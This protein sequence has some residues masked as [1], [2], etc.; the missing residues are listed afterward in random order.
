MRKIGNF[1]IFIFFFSIFSLSAHGAVTVQAS[2]DRNEVGPNEN[3]TL[4]VSVSS[5]ESFEAQDPRIPDL[6]GFELLNKSDQTAVSQKLVQG[7][8]GMQFETQRRREF[9]YSL[10]PQRQGNLSLPAIEVVVDGKV[11]RTQPIQ[12]K[13]SAKAGGG[14]GG[15]K[16]ARPRNGMPAMP[17]GFDNFDDMDNAEEELFNQLLRQRQQMMQGM[18]GAG[19]GGNTNGNLNFPPAQ[20]SGMADPQFRSLPKN[21]NEAFFIQVEVDKV[22]VYEGEQVTVNWYLYTRGQMESLDRLKFPDLRGFWKEIIEEVPTIQFSEEIVNGVAYKKALLASH[23][24]FPIKAGDAYIDEYKIKSRI[25]TP[26]G[27]GFLGQPYEYTKSSEKV[28]IHVKPLPLDGRPSDF[29]GAVGNFEINAA[30]EGQSFPVNQPLSLKIRF[31]GAGNAKVIDLPPLNLPQGLETY[32]TK[33]DSKFF[34]NGRSYKE[35]E[36]LVIPRQEGEMTIPAVSA[37]FFDPRAQKYYTKSTNP[38]KFNVV[39][40]PNAP[41]GSSNRVGE[42][43]AK[44]TAPKVQE[45]VLPAILST[46]EKPVT[47]SLAQNPMAW[48]GLYALIFVSLLWKAQKE[49]GFGQRRRSLKELVQKRWKKVDAAFSSQ[50][51]RSVGAEITNIFYLVLG[52][53]VGEGGGALEIHRLLEKA[54]PSLRRDY[55]AELTRSFEVFQTLSFAPDEMLGGLKDPAQ[56]KKELEQARKLISKIIALSDQ[57]PEKAEKEI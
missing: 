55:G 53:N 24:L 22:D 33:S 18:P 42:T 8:G 41:V 44:A 23:A 20:N 9:I 50:D 40:N 5:S 11:Y 10:A 46:W 51:I 52:E 4:V 19:G 2:V 37:S 1:L 3:F 36:V 12:I 7:K 25:R 28:K 48:T 32:D 29:S 45:N 27:G 6:D 56:V 16:Q 35:F 54:S 26:T 47:S 13:V 17:P 31:E 39:A 38:L 15:R 43:T 49:I 21:P 14:Q 57:G 30:V 34:K